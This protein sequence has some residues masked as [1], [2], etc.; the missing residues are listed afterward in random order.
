MIIYKTNVAYA[1]RTDCF[2][3]FVAR[4]MRVET[5]TFYGT[6]EEQKQNDSARDHGQTRIIKVKPCILF[7]SS[8]TNTN[9][10]LCVL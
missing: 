8:M 6:E 7:V 9:Y 5:C 4:A 10:I 2:Y 3:R 1:R